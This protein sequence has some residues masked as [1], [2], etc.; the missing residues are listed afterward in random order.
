[1]LLQFQPIGFCYES[2]KDADSILSTTPWPQ[3][4]YFSQDHHS[5]ELDGDLKAFLQGNADF[6]LKPRPRHV[7]DRS[8]ILRERLGPA[9]RYAGCSNTLKPRFASTRSPNSFWFGYR[10]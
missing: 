10:L 2:Y 7:R 8:E 6:E 1:M 9:D 3:V 4:S 5:T